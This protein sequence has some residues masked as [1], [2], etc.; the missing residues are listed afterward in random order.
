MK[1]GAFIAFDTFNS[2]GC[3]AMLYDGLLVDLLMD[4]A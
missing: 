2:R 3:A 4:I 1:K